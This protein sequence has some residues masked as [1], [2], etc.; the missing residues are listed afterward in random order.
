[1]TTGE[2]A[3]V[4]LTSAASASGHGMAVSILRKFPQL[5]PEPRLVGALL[6]PSAGLI[7][8][9][10]PLGLEPVAHKALAIAAFMVV[11]WMTGPIEHGITALL[12][13]FLFWALQVT[14]FSSAFQ[15]FTNTSPW[16]IFGALLM[17]EAASRTGLAKRVGCLVMHRLGT[18]YSQLLL[19]IITLV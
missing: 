4:S 17:G 1:M 15:G 18:S 5:L 3:E 7:I 16:F 8:W 2:L 10:L 11:Y 19:G 14:T 13:C 12:G 6:G 9:W